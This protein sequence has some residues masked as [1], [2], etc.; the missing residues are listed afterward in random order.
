MN[1]SM[2]LFIKAMINNPQRYTYGDVVNK[3]NK[4]IRSNKKCDFDTVEKIGSIIGKDIVTIN[5]MI[6]DLKEQ[7]VIKNLKDF[8]FLILECG[9]FKK[10]NIKYLPIAESRAVLKKYHSEKLRN[11]FKTKQYNGK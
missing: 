1:Q 5:N 9:E 4:V 2:I 10:P 3:I 11:Y 8:L 6:S 7:G